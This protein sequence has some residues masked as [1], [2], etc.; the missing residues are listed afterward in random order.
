VHPLPLTPPR[1]LLC[2]DAVVAVP[3]GGM[4]L[5]LVGTL[6]CCV[7]VTSYCLVRCPA[8]ALLTPYPRGSTAEDYHYTGPVLPHTVGTAHRV[9]CVVFEWR[10]G[11]TKVGPS[12]W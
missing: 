7:C 6:C 11:A 9:A 1:L 5:C 3:A 2:L 12:G 8:Q 4:A 10:A